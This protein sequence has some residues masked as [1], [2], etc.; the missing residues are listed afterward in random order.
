MNIRLKRKL[1]HSVPQKEKPFK[2]ERDLEGY[3]DF[4]E[5]IGDF[6]SKKIKT[7]SYDAEFEL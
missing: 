4:L 7:K 2:K 6:K 1:S 3:I 5:A